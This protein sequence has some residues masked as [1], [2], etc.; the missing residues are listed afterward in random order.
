[1][2]LEN[3]SDPFI[4][5]LVLLLYGFFKYDRLKRENSIFN[6]CIFYFILKLKFRFCAW[7]CVFLSFFV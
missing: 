6:F 5:S 2:V 3:S 7:L 4:Y 1:M